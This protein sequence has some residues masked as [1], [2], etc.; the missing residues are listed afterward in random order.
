MS[1]ETVLGPIASQALGHCQ[2]HEHLLLAMGTSYTVNPALWFDEV[3]RSAA[4]AARY[5]AAGGGAVV[6][7]QPVGCGRMAEGLAEISRRTGV[8]I[9]GSTG[10]HKLCFYPGDHWVRTMDQERLTRLFLQEL[11]VGM[12][13][14]GDKGAPTK[15]T[16]HRA[17]VIKTAL[18]RSPMEGR[19]GV[20]FQAAAQAALASGRPLM[21]HIEAGSQPLALVQQLRSMGLPPQ[22]LIFCHTDRAC[23]WETR[24]ALAETGIWLEMDTIGR[25]RY[26]DNETERAILGELL[27]R[28]YGGQLLLSLD[29]TRQ[30]LK[31]YTPDGVGL[32]YLLTTFLPSM[33]SA[34]VSEETIDQLTRSNPAAALSGGTP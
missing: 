19:Y 28:G 27:D 16:G 24:L 11:Q 34:G 3:D 4:E 20:L 2:C 15:Q 26:H 1:I 18:D 30:R 31:T 8:H 14:D 10:F 17:G 22:Q 12:Y 21:V 32:D 7:A 23:D 25:F 29:T 5:G 6:D 33:V 13:A 9:V